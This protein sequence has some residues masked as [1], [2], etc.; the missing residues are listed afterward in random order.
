MP[1]RCQRRR[2]PGSAIGRGMDRF[3]TLYSLGGSLIREAVGFDWS[4]G[5]LAKNLSSSCNH[6]LHGV[7]MYV[8]QALSAGCGFTDLIGLMEMVAAAWP[9]QD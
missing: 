5:T 6:P 2:R 3:A 1:P 9:K 8:P 4:N 7:V